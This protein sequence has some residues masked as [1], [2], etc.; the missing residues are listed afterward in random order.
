[1]SNITI[2]LISFNK[3]V[4]IDKA[5]LLPTP[6]SPKFDGYDAIINVNV[7]LQTF[8]DMFCF[9]T[10]YIDVNDVVNTDIKYYVL[11]DK[12]YYFIPSLG[13]SIVEVNPM[14]SFTPQ[15]GI[16]T[17]QVV[18]K[19]FTRY[20]A[21]LLFNTPYG[22]DLFNNE[23]EV[24]NS[25]SYALSNAWS[26]CIND[27]I[28]VSN[29]STN[30]EI[31][32]LGNINAKYTTNDFVGV[33]NICR[34]LFQQMISNDP[35]R[36]TNL[37]ERLA[38]D[39]Y[40]QPIR[41]GSN[42]KYYYLPF[43]QNDIIQ[44]QVKLYPSITQ[45]IAGLSSITDP[46]KFETV[47]N[48]TEQLKGRTY[49]INMVL[50]DKLTATTRLTGKCSFKV[51]GKTSSLST[52]DYL[53]I[54]QT[55]N[56]MNVT[57]KN[58][59][60]N[61]NTIQ[62]DIY[63]DVDTRVSTTKSILDIGFGFSTS[64]IT[65]YNENIQSIEIMEFGGIPL[66]GKG[67]QFKS[68]LSNIIFTATDAPL[69]SPGTSLTY[70]FASML[71]FNENLNFLNKWNLLNVTDMSY[72]FS[73]C[74]LFNNG[75]TSNSGT[76]PVSLTTSSALT[77]V[78]YMFNGCNAFNQ[79]VLISNVS[80]VDYMS[81]MFN[82][83]SLFNNGDTG[84]NGTKPLTFTTTERL[85][86]VT[87]MF[88][89][90]V[91]FNQ[92]VTY[93]NVSK[94][95]NMGVMFGGCTLFNNGNTSNL[96]TNPLTFITSSSLTNCFR[97][98]YNCSAFNQTVSITNLENVTTISSMFEGCGLFNNGDIA[99][100]ATKPLTFTTSNVLNSMLQLF[101]NCPKFNQ[102]VLFNPTQMNNN[103]VSNLT[104]VT[105]FYRMFENCNLFNNGNT[106]DVSSKPLTFITSFKLT[107]CS[108]VFYNC[109]AFNQTLNITDYSCVTTMGEFL[110]N[111]YIFN[112]GDTSDLGTK[113]LSF[114]T[115]SELSYP[116]NMF[117][118]C[119][120]FNQTVTFTSVANIS[121]LARM[122][123]GCSIFNNGDIN[124]NRTK[125]LTFTTSN[126]LTGTSSMF[127][128]CARFNQT[129]TISNVSRVTTMTQMFK[130]C[131]IFN[132]GYNSTNTSNKLFPTK[133]LLITNASNFGSSILQ[134][135]NKPVWLST[136]WAII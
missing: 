31:P 85:L 78:G 56:I 116:A 135:G 96:G 68:L 20:L 80:N 10:D 67:S 55:D 100:N 123:E 86:S 127:S 58:T 23:E 129:I 111:C 93:T 102:T 108:R 59:Q 130:D 122:F 89:N 66:Y 63:Y 90:C 92:T 82:G 97:V 33:Q 87:N 4:A 70:A 107:S 119:Y 54:I 39:E 113:Q 26:S 32:L 57:T 133:P 46:T 25:V 8:S 12:V 77:I 1:M 30:T 52:L 114:T 106:S 62:C 50:S 99:N 43:I 41:E 71:N 60:I 2:N 126:L 27:L 38:Q 120:K 19:D 81:F 128:G 115:T 7:D 47:G 11:T 65:Y 15:G 61:L 132:N 79:T 84:N 94:L 37:P 21:Y 36:F 98:F 5:G 125:P 17:N 14:V 51:V 112:N 45:P 124:D 18:G 24:V 53:P 83:C 40:V 42:L 29:K 105:S 109:N 104:N 3:T 110:Y 44:I 101:Y 134:N 48:N 103:T 34:E 136:S 91:K 73:G 88:C 72:M 118:N 121:T 117:V 74:A 76:N 95:V 69:I 75:N 22:V 16:E 9:Q 64:A 49:L 28:K 35:S 6:Y 13:S 131:L